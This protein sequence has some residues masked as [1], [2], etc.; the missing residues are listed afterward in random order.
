[1]AEGDGTKRL[2]QHRKSVSNSKRCRGI[3]IRSLPWQQAWLLV[4]LLPVAATARDLDAACKMRSDYDITVT[5]DALF[6][7]RAAAP[8]KRIEMRGGAL[9]ADGKTVALSPADRDRIVR[10]ERTVRTLVPPV[11][12]LG[13]RAVDL[14]AVAV[15]EEAAHVSP[16]SATNPQ[17]NARLSARASDLKARIAQSRTSKDWRGAAFNRYAA[18]TIADVL[19]LIGG[20]MAEQAL[21]VALRGDLA[22]ARALSDRAAG[23]RGALEQRIRA[24]LDVLEPEVEKLCPS[25]RALDRLE[26]GMTARLPDGSQLNLLEVGKQ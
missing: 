26:S 21:Q 16:R 9:V 7:E 2:L 15:R 18:Q 10:F 3:Q 19:P 1:M 12:Q 8:S 24:K 5:N 22:G 11:K 4:L 6:F 14:S 17:L 13:Q 20:D 23:L 25:L